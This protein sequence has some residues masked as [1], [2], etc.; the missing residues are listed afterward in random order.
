MKEKRKSKQYRLVCLKKNK[1]LEGIEFAHK[2]LVTGRNDFIEVSNWSNHIN[3]FWVKISQFGKE[4]VIDEG[5][6]IQ[7]ADELKRLHEVGLEKSVLD[8]LIVI[9]NPKE[10]SY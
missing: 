5:V 6:I 9:N 8:E 7:L 4:I 2:K 1:Y 3:S 10:I